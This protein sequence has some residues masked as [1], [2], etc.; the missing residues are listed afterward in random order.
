MQGVIEA[1]SKGKKHVPYKESEL[2]RVLQDSLGGNCKTTLLV[3]ASPHIYNRLETVNSLDF[4]KR[5]KM[6]KTKAIQNLELTPKQLREQ[7]AKLKEQLELLKL[8]KMEDADEVVKEDLAKQVELNELLTN[9]LKAI[10]LSI[11]GKDDELVQLNAAKADLET[12]LQNKQEDIMSMEVENYE[13]NEKIDE[14]KEEIVKEQKAY[15][16]LQDENGNH[17]QRIEKLKTELNEMTHEKEQLKNENDKYT[18]EKEAQAAKMKHLEV[19]IHHLQENELTRDIID[20][21]QEQTEQELENTRIKLDQLNG[22]YFNLE[23]I[24]TT[25]EN[26]NNQ[27]KLTNSNLV[28]ETN[29]QKREL[30]ELK[31]KITQLEGSTLDWNAKHAELLNKYNQEKELWEARYNDLE[32][33]FE[34]TQHLLQLKRAQFE[35]LNKKYINE[36]LGEVSKQKLIIELKS[37]DQ[38]SSETPQSPQSMAADS[39]VSQG[40]GSN[41]GRM[42]NNDYIVDQF[43]KSML[44]QRELS[45][46]VSKL[47]QQLKYLKQVYN[48]TREAQIEND[49]KVAEK[50]KREMQLEAAIEELRKKHPTMPDAILREYASRA[51]DGMTMSQ[52]EQKMQECVIL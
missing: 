27:L 43:S 6:I 25:F 30:N 50:L 33:T 34:E 14:L 5:C 22:E 12:E 16:L 52:L 41:S 17:L 35:D 46:H 47:E 13:L 49:R 11:N 44:H 4:G 48:N 8:S 40:I 51:I 9:K 32:S 31:L 28:N 38:E 23:T 42:A 45:E 24:K 29:D 7:I 18:R 3:A 10:E 21:L 37:D 19:Q 2:T 15:K 36:L 39:P 26:E 20:I 1:L